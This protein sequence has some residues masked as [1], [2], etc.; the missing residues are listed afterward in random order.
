MEHGMI[1]PYCAW[2]SLVHDSA[3]ALPRIQC[4][5]AWIT[6][7]PPGGFKE[8]S[9]DN[10][11]SCTPACLPCLGHTVFSA[12]FAQSR[13]DG[14]SAREQK[15]R[16]AKQGAFKESQRASTEQWGGTYRSTSSAS[17]EEGGAVKGA[18]QGGGVV[19]QGEAA[20]GG[21]LVGAGL[22]SPMGFAT[23]CLSSWRPCSSLD[24]KIS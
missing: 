18:A 22:A 21:G 13:A 12:P 9:T 11:R 4:L 5:S 7:I 19:D 16:L 3:V 14:L 6:N 8:D 15:L 24:R 17:Q 2:T 23:V 10:L 1:C 20:A